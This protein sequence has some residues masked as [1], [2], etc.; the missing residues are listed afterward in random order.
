MLLINTSRL[1]LGVETIACTYIIVLL[2]VPTRVTINFN[3]FKHNFV[4]VLY[5]FATNLWGERLPNCSIPS[6][7]SSRFVGL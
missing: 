4:Q 7:N 3:Y 1:L 6:I 5:V 2:L